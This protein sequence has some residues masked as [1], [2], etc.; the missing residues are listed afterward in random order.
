MAISEH[1]MDVC[2][3]IDSAVEHVAV[4]HKIS[5]YIFTLLFD[6]ELGW[7]YQLPEIVHLLKNKIQL[8]HH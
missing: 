5:G 1:G 3:G 6:T 7:R 2:K 4:C 8:N